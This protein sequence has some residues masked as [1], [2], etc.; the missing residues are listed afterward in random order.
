MSKYDFFS[1][2]KCEYSGIAVISEHRECK[3]PC[4]KDANLEGHGLR[5]FTK[6]DWKKIYLIVN[7]ILNLQITLIDGKV[8]NFDFPEKFDPVWITACNGFKL[9]NRFKGAEKETSAITANKLI[10]T[11]F[12][13]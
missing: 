1:C 10:D 2:R 11:S 3:H 7:E 5:T 8:T 6:D 12:G 4:I 13:D 9:A